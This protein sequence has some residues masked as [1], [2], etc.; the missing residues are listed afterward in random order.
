MT[1][2]TYLDE[3]E[4]CRGTHPVVVEMLKRVAR[5]QCPALP[6]DAWDCPFLRTTEQLSEDERL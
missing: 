4:P 1:E 3:D 6:L 2:S 5:H